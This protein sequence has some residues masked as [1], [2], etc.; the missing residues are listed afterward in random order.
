MDCSSLV[1]LAK[2]SHT[3]LSLNSKGYDLHYY[4]FNLNLYDG[5][6]VLSA[7]DS[8]NQSLLGAEVTAINGFSMKHVLEKFKTFLSADNPVKLQ[9]SYRQMCYVMEPY[10]YLGIA[11]KNQPLTLTVK[12]SAG[13]TQTLSV[14]ALDKSA[15]QNANFKTLKDLQTGT[16]A[17]AYDKTKAYFAKTLNSHT[18][19]IQ[20]NTCA[21]DPSLPM[22]TFCQQIQSELNSGNYSLIFVDLRNNGGGSDGVIAPLLKLLVK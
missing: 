3:S 20:Y 10:L 14:S 17:T 18:Y 9:Y 7:V 21:E 13:N 22:K 11:K 8:A 6:W 16:A 15:F 5:T 4:L 2:D 1:A 12:D 19:Y